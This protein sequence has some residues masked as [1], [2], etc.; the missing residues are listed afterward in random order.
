MTAPDVATATAVVELEP[1]AMSSALSARD[2]APIAVLRAP[3]AVAATPV[4][5]ALVPVAP[6]LS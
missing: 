6:L 2:P 5:S 4:A 1:S 3:A